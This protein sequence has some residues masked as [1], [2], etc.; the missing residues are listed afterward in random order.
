M[1]RPR[2]SKSEVLSSLSL[3]RVRV[4]VDSL[5]SVDHRTDYG[6]PIQGSTVVRGAIIIL[7]RTRDA[8]AFCKVMALFLVFDINVYLLR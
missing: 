5:R 2:D 4:V 7:L 8:F 3:S 1:Q 6:P